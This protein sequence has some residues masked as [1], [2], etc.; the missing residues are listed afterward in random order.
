MYIERPYISMAVTATASAA[1]SV[2]G[3]DLERDG[4][5][6]MMNCIDTASVERRT[7]RNVWRRMERKKTIGG[8]RK[9]C[10]LKFEGRPREGRGLSKPVCKPFA[11]TYVL[12]DAFILLLFRLFVWLISLSTMFTNSS[13]HLT[14]FSASSLE[15]MSISS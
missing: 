6:K 14:A 3:L 2:T 7:V 8:S 11:Y 5:G 9:R 13:A 12:L 15:T 10:E 1:Q 4:R